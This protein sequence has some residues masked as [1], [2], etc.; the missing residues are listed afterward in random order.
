MLSRLFWYNIEYMGK[1][2]HVAGETYAH[3]RQV[4]I[5]LHNRSY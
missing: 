1:T 5:Q 3:A 2:Y 4:A